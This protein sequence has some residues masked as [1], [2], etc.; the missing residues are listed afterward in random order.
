MHRLP[1]YTDARG[2]LCVCEGADLPFE[3]RR[4]YCLYDMRRDAVRG[5]HSHR[6]LR[7][8]MI[9]VEG[10]VEVELH[11][12]RSADSFQLGHPAD[13]LHVPPMVWRRITGRAERSV[14]TVLASE[15]HDPD[16]YIYDFDAFLREVRGERGS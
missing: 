11:D 8:L 4:M 15:P 13:V 6:R 16:D 7:Q 1:T 3:V 14:V 12:G 2:S 5:A 10:A 9:C